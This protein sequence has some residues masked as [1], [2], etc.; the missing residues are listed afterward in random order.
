VMSEVCVTARLA[1]HQGNTKTL[2]LS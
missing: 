2:K 1:A